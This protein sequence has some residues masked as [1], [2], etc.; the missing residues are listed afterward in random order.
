MKASGFEWPLRVDLDAKCIESLRLLKARTWLTCDLDLRE[1]TKS[2][3][4]VIAR[5]LQYE[6]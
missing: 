3:N 5:R 6:G 1:K 4:Q 2:N